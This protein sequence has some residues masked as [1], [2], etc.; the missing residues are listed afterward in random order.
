MKYHVYP[1]NSKSLERELAQNVGNAFEYFPY[2]VA[3]VTFFAVVN[4]FKLKSFRVIISVLENNTHQK[5]NIFQVSKPIVASF[6]IINACG[7]I[8]S[9]CGMMFAVGFEWQAINLASSFL[10]LGVGI[11]DAFVML[12]S[13]HRICMENPNENTVEIFRRTYEE[14]A[15]SITITS[16][17]NICSFAIG[18]FVPS[19]DTVR[20][21]CSYTAVG[22][23][24]VYFSTLILFGAAI[25]FSHN[26]S[27]NHTFDSLF[28][29]QDARPLSLFLFEEILMPF[30][31]N[32]ITKSL[33]LVTWAFFIGLSIFHLQF[34]NEGLERRKIGKVFF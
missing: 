33:V 25:A 11:D 1:V 4:G 29:A 7:S 20:I 12:G 26:S 14:A 3:F 34:L 27:E 15:I 8:M 32:R 21:F 31:F 22:L 30:V 18:A 13:Y 6:G 2:S 16:L 9:S 24:F 10:L 19:F 28:E 17:T 23:T 5:V